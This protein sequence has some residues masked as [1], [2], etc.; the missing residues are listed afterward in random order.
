MT[1]TR[2][3]KGSHPLPPPSPRLQA[4]YIAPELLAGQKYGSSVRD[5]AFGEP[6]SSIN[7][8]RTRNIKYIY[9]RNNLRML[10]G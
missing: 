2:R 1:R 5:K 7:L 6:M 4:E 3:A 10:T 9:G 8:E